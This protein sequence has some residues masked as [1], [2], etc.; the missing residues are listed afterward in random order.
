MAL[1]LPWSGRET[2]H[3]FASAAGLPILLP[4]LRFRRRVIHVA[5]QSTVLFLC[6]TLAMALAFLAG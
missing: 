4:I 1:A 6:L 3:D 2:F 5:T